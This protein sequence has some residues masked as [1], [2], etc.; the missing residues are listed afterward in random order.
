[1]VRNNEKIIIRRRNEQK[2][3]DNKKE[4]ETKLEREGEM[5]VYPLLEFVNVVTQREAV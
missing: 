4:E 1:M 2:I 5:L 3:K